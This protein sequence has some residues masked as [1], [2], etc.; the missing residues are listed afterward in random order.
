MNASPGHPAEP[1]PS[2]GAP[3]PVAFADID[4]AEPFARHLTPVRRA[5]ER[6][7]A[8]AD[9]DHVH[10]AAARGSAGPGGPLPH[11]AAIQRSFGPSDA[12]TLPLNQVEG[13]SVGDIVATTA[14]AGA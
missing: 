1:A 12:P 4:L 14:G 9:A 13:L 8:A 7:A 10:A 5:A 6:A 2:A 3:S 11:V